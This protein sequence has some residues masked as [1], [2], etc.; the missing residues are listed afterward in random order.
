MTTVAIIGASG[1]VGTSLA[2]HLAGRG[3]ATILFTRSRERAR[4]LWPLPNAR[5]VEVDVRDGAQLAE[6][7]HGVDVL[8]N[9][10][11]ILN[12][13]GSNGEGFRRAHVDVTA[14]ALAA[15][16]T[17][18][19]PRYIHMSALNAD[20]FGPSHY[21]R[22]KGEAE[23]LVTARQ[24]KEAEHELQTTIFRPSII[25][26]PGDD[27]YNR[28]DRLLNLAPLVFPLAAS[29]SRFQP[30]YIGNVV[31][32]LLRAID[33]RDCNGQVLELAGPEIVT[34]REVVEYVAQHTGRRVQILP[35]SKSLGMLQAAILEW[36]PGKPLSRDN[37]RSAEVDSVL[38]GPD[39]LAQL[40]IE[41]VPLGAIVPNM[42]ARGLQVRYDRY[43]GDA[44]RN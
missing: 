8:C 21:M 2:N 42:L 11:G 34:L 14:A 31:D 25:F 20:P 40:G 26:G 23:A 4:H 10:A 16:D 5:V 15:C 22:S 28:F 35:L 6:Q 17:A 9:F 19:V 32:A 36:V 41:P 39:G 13:S 33:T 29:S 24:S 44:R 3:D 12:E 18:R 27:F 30:V 43:R 7:L 1:F 38:A 37:L